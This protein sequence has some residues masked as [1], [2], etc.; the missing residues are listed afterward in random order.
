MRVRS[1]WLRL[2][3]GENGEDGSAEQ[4]WALVTWKRG[5]CCGVMER[6]SYASITQAPVGCRDISG[7]LRLRLGL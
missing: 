7:R 4:V 6:Q 2:W 5:Q 1:C 3:L